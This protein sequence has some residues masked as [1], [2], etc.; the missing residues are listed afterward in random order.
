MSEHERCVLCDEKTG[1]SGK[2]EDSYYIGDH[3]PFCEQCYNVIEEILTERLREIQ[4][5][6]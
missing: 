4:E 6:R 3:G 1:K 5:R 2:G